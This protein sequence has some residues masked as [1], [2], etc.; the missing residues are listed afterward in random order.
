MTGYGRRLARGEIADQSRFAIDGGFSLENVP[1]NQSFFEEITRPPST[2]AN[3]VPSG[4]PV[5]GT[6]SSM[7]C[8]RRSLPGGAGEPTSGCDEGAG[9]PEDRWSR[10]AGDEPRDAQTV[11]GSSGSM[12]AAVGRSWELRSFSARCRGP[13]TWT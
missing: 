7:S 4:L 5:G 2:L 11:S 12:C 1:R 6:S 9:G 13:A 10:R 3:P 8:V